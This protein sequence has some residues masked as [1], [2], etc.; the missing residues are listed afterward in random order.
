MGAFL[1]ELKGLADILWVQAWLSLTATGGQSCPLGTCQR[2]AW[3]RVDHRSSPTETCCKANPC[4]KALCQGCWTPLQ[5]QPPEMKHQPPSHFLCPR[6]L[7]FP[8]YF[9]NGF[10]QDCKSQ[11]QQKK[12]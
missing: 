9:P 2:E 3:P 8:K 4:C 6:C 10:P 11:N 12:K 5:E 1:P 7:S